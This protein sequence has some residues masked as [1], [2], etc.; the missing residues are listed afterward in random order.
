MSKKGG[1]SI[2]QKQQ[3]GDIICPPPFACYTQNNMYNI[4]QGDQ[5]IGII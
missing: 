3:C 5:V 4:K 1:Y 2:E